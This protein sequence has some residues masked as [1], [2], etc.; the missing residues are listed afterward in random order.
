[1]GEAL[2]GQS[3]NYDAAEL[4][5]IFGSTWANEGVIWGMDLSASGALNVT[6]GAGQAV[7]DDEAGQKY[8]L[9]NTTTSAAVTIG[10]AAGTYNVYCYVVNAATGGTALGFGATTGTL[11]AYA[12]QVGRAIVAASGTRTTDATRSQ[13]LV[14]GLDQYALKTVSSTQTFA[15]P[16][17]FTGDVTF[18]RPPV[19][20]S[21]LYYNNTSIGPQR[22][23][24]VFAWRNTNP[25]VNQAISNNTWTAIKYNN[26]W[27]LNDYGTSSSWQSPAWVQNDAGTNGRIRLPVSGWYQA[28]ATAE[29]SN[30][31]VGRRDIMLVR[32]ASPGGAANVLLGFARTWQ[33]PATSSEDNVRTSSAFYA[34]ATDM[35]EVWVRQTSGASLGILD[36]RQFTPP[37]APNVAT[38]EPNTNSVTVSLI[39]AGGMTA[40]A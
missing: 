4:R 12:V 10:S 29:F 28:D 27:A 23:F 26:W 35:L 15:G 2:F 34:N 31:S 7:V 30:N 36:S 6:V 38:W 25:S 32:T 18:A 37:D 13:A 9:D 22:R 40:N 11:P 39:A 16:Q 19:M 24:Q 21:G 20:Q 33:N 1:M 17:T 3:G 5:P 8:L 14:R